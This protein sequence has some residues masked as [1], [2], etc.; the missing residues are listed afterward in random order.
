MTIKVDILLVDIVI[1]NSFKGLRYDNKNVNF[2]QN[3][4]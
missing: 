1:K 2:C 4:V 3:M